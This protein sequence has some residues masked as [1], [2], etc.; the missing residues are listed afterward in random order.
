MRRSEGR[1]GGNRGKGEA[2]DNSMRSMPFPQQ[3]SRGRRKKKEEQKTF[4]RSSRSY[5]RKAAPAELAKSREKK[6]K[7]KG[8]KEKKE[9][10]FFAV[11][12]R[13]QK[14]KKKKK[15]RGCVIFVRKRGRVGCRYREKGKER[16]EK[17]ER[18]PLNPPPL[19]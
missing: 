3:P 8:K 14:K 5:G 4:E 15:K 2:I 9:D 13:K 10:S 6:E 12:R 19:A 11:S 18:L 1:K 16:R 7:K 17:K